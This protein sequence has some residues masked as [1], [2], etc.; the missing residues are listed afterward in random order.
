MLNQV[1]VLLLSQYALTG[2][3][4]KIIYPQLKLRLPIVLRKT[5]PLCRFEVEPIEE[6]DYDEHLISL[7]FR[8]WYYSDDVFDDYINYIAKLKPHYLFVFDAPYVHERP[9]KVDIEAFAYR[10]SYRCSKLVDLMRRESPETILIA[11][12]ISVLFEHKQ[13][14]MDFLMHH[15]HLFDVYSVMCANNMNDISIGMI[16]SMTKEISDLSKKP[17]WLLCAIPC[18]ESMRTKDISYD[19]FDPLTEDMAVYKMN[20]TF[21]LFQA[22]N[23]D[24][25][26]F[27]FGIGKDTFDPITKP[28]PSDFWNDSVH[29]KSE[30]KWDWFHFLGLTDHSDRVKAYLLKG[31]LNLAKKNNV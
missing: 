27:Y 18:G 19:A 4:H 11:P 1:N 28:D 21:E 24:T 8:H 13:I 14:Y 26:L 12:N 22:I 29:F 2:K 31:I 3:F 20:R 17:I 7:D 15:H 6:I 10:L 25:S 30:N 16:S 23:Q 5:V 9:W